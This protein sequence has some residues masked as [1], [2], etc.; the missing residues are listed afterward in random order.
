MRD[1]EGF[2]VQCLGSQALCVVL[3]RFHV[4]LQSAGWC[5]GAQGSV[6]P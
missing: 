4:A 3:Y 2:S 6:F 5:F 1:V